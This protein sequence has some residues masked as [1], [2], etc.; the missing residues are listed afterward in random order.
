MS[1]CINPNEHNHWAVR[2][3]ALCHYSGKWQVAK[4]HASTLYASYS[5]EWWMVAR[6]HYLELG[7]KYKDQLPAG[8]AHPPQ[9][10]QTKK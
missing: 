8:A 7:G 9:R 5:H 10:S 1:G 2:D 3:L 4:N 6:K